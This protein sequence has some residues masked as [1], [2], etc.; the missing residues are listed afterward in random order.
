MLDVTA[1]SPEPTAAPLAEGMGEHAGRRPRRAVVELAVFAAIAFVPQLLS[2]PGAVQADTKTYLYLDPGR[3]LRQSMSMWDPS[4]G[5]GTVTHQQI[6]YLFPMGPFFWALHHLGVAVWVAQRLWV[7]AILLAAAGGVLFLA[8]TVDLRGPG[9]QVAAA[10]FMLSPYFLQYVGRISVILLPWAGLPWMVALTIRSVRRGGWR[11]PALFA[12]VVFSVSSTNASSLL[13]VGLAPAL[14]LPVAVASGQATWRQAWAAAWRIGLLSVLV[15]LWWIAGLQI[16]GAY[17]IDVLKYTETVPAVSGPASAAEVLRGLGY[18]YY[19]GGDAYGPWAPTLGQLTQQLWTVGASF[20]VPTLAVAGAVLTRWRHRSYFVLIMVVGVV[21]AVGSH[22]YKAPSAVGRIL[23]AF[24][25]H[26]T[27]GLAMRSTDRVSPL[28]VLATAMLLGSGVTALFTRWPRVGW[29]AAGAAG[30]AVVAANPAVWNGTT[31]AD[32]FLQPATPPPA[33]RQ[34]AHALNHENPSSRVLAIPGE[35]FAQYRW[36]DTVDPVWPALLSPD[37]PFVTR[38]QQVLGSVATEDTLIA[39]D[40]PMQEG[41]L[42]PRAIAP[43]ARLMSAGDVLVQNDLGFERYLQPEPQALWSQLSP[44]PAGLGPATG[45]GPPTPNIPKLPFVDEQVVATPPGAPVPSPLEILAV[46]G[47][48]P[49]VRA[50]PVGQPVVVDG[51]ARGIADLAGAGLLPGNPT[52]LYAGTLDRAPALARSAL[53]AGADLVVTDTNRKQLFRWNT[54]PA[55]AGAT[56]TARAHP[57]DPSASPLGL[58][59]GQ[60]PSAQSVAVYHG[61]RSVTASSYGAPNN[62]TPEDRAVGAIDGNPTTA[63]ETSGNSTPV[64]QWWQVVTMSPVTTGHVTL[65]Q[66][67]Y[68]NPDRWITSATLTFDGSHPLRVHLG[69]SSRTTPGQTVTFPTRRFSTL[70]ITIDT[71]N[72]TG[73][74]HNSGS[75]VGFAEVGLAGITASETISMPTDLLRAAGPASLSHRLTIVMTRRRVLPEPPRSDPEPTLDR[76]FD[77]P[78]ARTFTLTGSAAVNPLIPDDAIDRLVGRQGSN[79]QGVVAYSNGRLPGD[80]RAGASAALDGNPATVWEPGMGTPSPDD[81][82]QVDTPQPVRVDQLHLQVVADGFHSV[83]T[84]LTVR[85]DSGS[86]G[87]ALPPIADGKVKGNIVAVDVHFP[88]VTGRHL[89]V[90]FDG[91]RIETTRNYFSQRPLALPIGIAELGVPAVH[92]GALPVQVPSPCRSDLLQVDGVPVWLRV[93]GSTADA[94]AGT[95]L[96]VS[97]CGPDASG[98]TLGPGHHTVSSTLGTT[99]CATGPG[100]R[101]A[102][103]DIN[104]LVFDSA[105][106]G[107]PEPS[108]TPLGTASLSPPAPVVTVVSSSATSE[109]LRISGARPRTPFWLVLGQ[110][111]NRGWQATTGNGSNLGPPTLVDGFAN[112]WLVQPS[113]LRA[114][115][116]SPVAVTLRWTPQRRVDI[117]LLVSAL[118][119][120]A[121]LLL[122]IGG[123]RRRRRLAAGAMPADRPLLAAPWAGTTADAC[124]TSW[125]VAVAA[126]AGAGLAVAAISQVAAGAAVTVGVLAALLVPRGRVILAGGAVVLAAGLAVAVPVHQW[127]VP[128]PP[129]GDWPNAMMAAGSAAWMVVSFVAA[130]VLVGTVGRRW[131]RRPR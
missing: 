105:P 3:F 103:Y 16:E 50:E 8:R 30:I 96:A 15:S 38:E 126:A 119:V 102:G 34:A 24:Y 60:P 118:A 129:D 45:Y 131:G 6:G 116:A 121:C 56:L 67:S 59:P 90:V 91:F 73:R 70:R 130:D 10:A 61:V 41:S 87:V 125:A 64:G 2:Q 20:A 106:G 81:W 117:A 124:P 112:G 28:V 7:G 48:R 21:L 39:L 17:G 82:I 92:A 47:T 123:L 4:V 89:R 11:D 51:D 108:G 13:Y 32:H 122:A 44:S 120:L 26:S 49:L 107:R 101:C 52:I 53:A 55:T 69:T 63:W 36:G 65:L 29:A 27:V 19:Y 18:W 113:S 114:G 75:S 14:W 99:G 58:F 79:G 12:L 115:G 68:A 62:F 72:R 83:P 110:S 5:L 42:V 31:V 78:T 111:L 57:N 25:T 86:V 23:R 66:P 9:R 37:R 40:Q 95:Q 74:P 84:H 46:P 104:Q 94:L 128:A 109:H 71:V 1:A 98:I 97:L 43:M 85:D 127:L 22:P 35:N 33:V 76:S 80:L 54:L 93:T 77:L 100:G 88:A